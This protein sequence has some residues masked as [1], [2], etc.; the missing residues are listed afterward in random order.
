MYFSNLIVGVTL[1]AA[2]PAAEV[3]GFRRRLLRRI[4]AGHGHGRDGD[5][6]YKINT[7]LKNAEVIPIL[8]GRGCIQL[9]RR[10]KHE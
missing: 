4:L 7:R 8:L 5:C 1:D 10:G 6:K 2:V 9:L 3:L